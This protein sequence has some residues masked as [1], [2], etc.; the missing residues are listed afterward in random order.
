MGSGVALF[1]YSAAGPAPTRAGA[2]VL[3]AAAAIE[4]EIF[5]MD[6]DIGTGRQHGSPIRIA[7]T[8]G[9]VSEFLGEIAN[10]RRAHPD[11][12]IEV[13]DVLDPIE[14]LNHRRCDLAVALLRSPPLRFAGRQIAVLQQAPYGKRGAGALDPLGWGLDFDAALSGAHWASA[15]PAGEAA[16]AAGLVTCNSWPQLKQAVVAGLGRAH[17]WCFAGDAD[18]ALERL[19]AP[20]PRHDSPLWLLHRAKA[21]PGPALLRLIDALETAIA[22]RVAV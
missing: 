15:N 11:C 1:D 8:A 10:V 7:G 12:P 14:A 22:D 9:I 17:L 5:A 20:D 18:P 2:R 21:P 4:R 19:A 3:A 6:S 13:L 16:L